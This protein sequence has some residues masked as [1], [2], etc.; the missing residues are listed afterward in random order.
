MFVSTFTIDTVKK[1]RAFVA[2]STYL[3]TRVV[4]KQDN[5]VVDG[6][7]I[8]GLFS[9]DLSRPIS[10]EFENDEEYSLFRQAFDDYL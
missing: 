10:V 3:K 4:A 6:K 1:I 2:C 5:Y 9:L 8:M 7:S